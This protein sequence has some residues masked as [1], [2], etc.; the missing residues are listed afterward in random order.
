[1]KNCGE[2]AGSH[3]VL[4]F[5]SS[6]GDCAK[7]RDEATEIVNRLNDRPLVAQSALRFRAIRWENLPPGLSE[8]RDFQKRIDKLLSR[9]GYEEFGIYIGF[10]AQRLG[11]PTPRFASGTVEEFENSVAR[12]RRTGSPEEVLFYFISPVILT[13]PIAKFRQE[14]WDRGFLYAD[15]ENGAFV[16]VLEQHLGEI[17]DNWFS[18]PRI[19]RQLRRRLIWSV[20]ATVFVA[21]AAWGIYEV[22]LTTQ[23]QDAKMHLEGN[24]FTVIDYKDDGEL[25]TALQYT[26][27]PGS[28]FA[29]PYLWHF[30]EIATKSA[31]YPRNLR[32][33]HLV[34]LPVNDQVVLEIAKFADLYQVWLNDAS[35]TDT[36]IMP[37]KKL[38]KL[39]SLELSGT[40]LSRAAVCEVERSLPKLEVRSCK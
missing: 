18:W 40:S 31:L 15:V 29:D 4:V 23:H 1:M 13:S 35:I 2:S 28:Q 10:V 5:I 9:Y 20:I 36:G 38:E 3:E 16:H 21:A 26:P 6:P 37:L 7:E 34:G 11:T 39:K 22:T 32:T 33:I 19:F 17:A 25:S 14:L 12:R 8:E 24:G 30:G 27:A